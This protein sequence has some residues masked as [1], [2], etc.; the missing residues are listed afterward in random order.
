MATKALS[1]TRNGRAGERSK[2]GKNGGRTRFGVALVAGADGRTA[3]KALDGVARVRE[4]RL[5][6]AHEV[7]ARRNSH[8]KD[9]DDR[10]LS[11]AP[12]RAARRDNCEVVRGV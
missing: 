9:G 8:H 5:V 12:L 4:M 2:E 7:R 3:H 6:A 1:N 10:L 11:L